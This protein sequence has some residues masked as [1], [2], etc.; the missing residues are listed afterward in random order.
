MCVSRYVLYVHVFLCVRA[1]NTHTHIHTEG[2][3]VQTLCAA[4]D[5]SHGLYCGADDVVVGVLLCERVSTGLIGDEED[6]REG[7]RRGR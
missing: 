3:G 4:H 6:K 1:Y 2:V 5:G 7:K